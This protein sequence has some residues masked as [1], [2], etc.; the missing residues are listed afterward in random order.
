M[1]VG[2]TV[3]VF[4]HPQPVRASSP[5]VAADEVVGETFGQGRDLATWR[6]LG[7]RQMTTGGRPKLLGISKRGNGYLR[8]VLIHGAR[9]ALPTLSRSEMS[10]IGWLRALMARP[11]VK[12]LV[13]ALATKLAW[14]ICAELRTGQR[15]EMRAAAVS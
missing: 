15:F 8:K 1:P 11:R 14:T 13:V 2:Q 7:P 3:G 5:E 6:G 4:R 10:L 9:A 12:T